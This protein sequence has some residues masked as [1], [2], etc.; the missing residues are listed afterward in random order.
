[1]ALYVI[2]TI[3]GGIGLGSI[4]LHPGRRP[5]T[6]D[7]QHKAATN[8]QAEH[9]EFR[10]VM[11]TASDGAVLRAWF[12]R[13]AAANGHAVI[14]LH[15]VSDNRLGV[16]GY[17]N[18]LA[19]NRYSVLLPDARAHGVSGGEIATYGLKESD[20]IHQWVNW[21]AENDH[22]HCIFGLGESMGAAR[23]CSR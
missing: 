16:Y 4:A 1:V 6:A 18:W 9:A 15:G 5:L 7:D 11:L 12:I 17:G 3:F 14:L 19:K 22:P 13:P 10:N 2:G 21:L 20:D 23:R 8:A